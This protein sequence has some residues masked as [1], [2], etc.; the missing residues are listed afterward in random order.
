MGVKVRTTV[1]PV[2]VVEAA[3]VKVAMAE[4]PMAKVTVI[5]ITVMKIAVAKVPGVRFKRV[6]VEE[7]STIMPVV[8]PVTPA[9][10]KT[11]EVPD[12]KSDP[13]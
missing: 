10:A 1:E 6:M 8:S 3:V 4:P 7:C 2:A 13:E 11:S 9:P 5:E 12:S